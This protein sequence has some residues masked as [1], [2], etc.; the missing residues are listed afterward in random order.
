MVKNV[1]FKSIAIYSAMS[2]FWYTV[3]SVAMSLAISVLSGIYLAMFLFRIAIIKAVPVFTHSLEKAN[4]FAFHS[5]TSQIK[6]KK[7]A[8]HAASGTGGIAAALIAS[9]CP[10][11]GAP[12]LALWGAPLALT[13]LPFQGLEIKLFSILL[14][15]LAIYLVA[16][17]IQKN[18][19]CNIKPM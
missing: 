13:A 5:L 6:E 16:E 3:F 9:G 15:S 1:A 10:S 11:C 17:N 14:L 7:D 12:L 8:K 4:K 2:G 19:T 18:L